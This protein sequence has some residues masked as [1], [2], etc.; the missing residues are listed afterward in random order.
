MLLQ[1]GYGRI[2]YSKYVAQAQY[3]SCAADMQAQADHG[4]PIYVAFVSSNMLRPDVL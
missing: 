1:V 4:M 3:S 2:T